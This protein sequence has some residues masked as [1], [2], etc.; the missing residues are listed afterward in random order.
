MEHGIGSL[1]SCVNSLMDFYLIEKSYHKLVRLQILV[2]NRIRTPDIEIT[3][4]LNETI[5]GHFGLK[6]VASKIFEIKRGTKNRT[7][8]VVVVFT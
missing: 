1:T 8:E 3:R 4:G 2:K 5:F 6:G 7:L